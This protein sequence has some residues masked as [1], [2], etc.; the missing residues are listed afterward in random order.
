MAV[1]GQ[2][3]ARH[4][5]GDVLALDEHVSLADG[6]GLVVQL[7]AEH[8]QACGRVQ[9]R[10]IVLGHRQHAA[11]ARRRIIDGPDHAGLRQQV[12]VFDEQQRHHQLDDLT[13]REMFPRR[14]V[15]KF[16]ESA[17]QLFESQAHLVVVD[18]PGV[19][20]DTG[21]FLGHL[22]QQARLGQAVD[23]GRELEP[24]E[25]VAHR[26]REGLDVGVEVVGDMVG[27]ADQLRHIHRRGVVEALP[28]RAQQE[29]LRVQAFARPLL[30][31]RQNCGLGR[32]Q[33]A[34]QPPQ[35]RERQDNLAVVGLLVVAPEQI[36]DR[37]DKGRQ[38]LM[39][40]ALL[41]SNQG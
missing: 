29:R 5:V 20:I 13:R 39:I 7:L 16:R 22:V 11:G 36:G 24:L 14:L 33:H 32:R 40:H 27:V 30:E 26:R 12:V 15:G 10:H 4:D 41:P 34:V 31:L 23:L 1:V 6:V 17:D 38:R 19:Q 8:G 35:N 21:E 25:D 9:A 2:G 3:V 37:P 18:R 28:R